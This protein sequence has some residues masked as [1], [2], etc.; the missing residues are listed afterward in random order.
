M[1][2]WLTTEL[3]SC[4]ATPWTAA[5]QA[6]LSI[7]NSQSLLNSCPLSWWCHHPLLLPPSIFPNI[8]VF[9]SESVLLIRLPKYWSFSFSIS[10]SNEY[11]GLI[12]LRMD[13]FD[14]LA[15]QGAL[16]S[17]L[18]HHSSKASIFQHS[19]FFHS[20]MFMSKNETMKLPST[21]ILP[22]HSWGQPWIA[23]SSFLLY[24][25]SSS[26]CL[27]DFKMCSA[28]TSPILIQ[29]YL[30]NTCPLSPSNLPPP[31]YSLN[32]PSR[33]LLPDHSSLLRDP[34]LPVSLVSSRTCPSSFPSAC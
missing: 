27:P 34:L 32:N 13:W 4:S 9:S 8:R 31:I 30:T 6:S 17:V 21:P 11:S 22:F 28:H 1:S 5:C 24:F 20:D 33:P 23:F 15:V 29:T 3:C 16:K 7:T 10:P 19:A 12:S 26:K 18:Q 25:I 2:N 14:L